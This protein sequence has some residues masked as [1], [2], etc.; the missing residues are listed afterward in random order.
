MGLLHTSFVSGNMFT[1][2]SDYGTT[3][4]SGI[5]EFT[6]RVNVQSGALYADIAN[7]TAVSGAYVATSGAL[8]TDI[9][10]L[11]AVSGA[12]YAVSGAYVATSGATY[13]FSKLVS[14]TDLPMYGNFAGI[15]AGEG[16][17]FTAGSVIAGEDASATNKGIIEIATEDEVQTGTDTIRAVVPDTLQAVMSPVGSIVAWLK[18]LAGVPQTLPV[19]WKECDGSAISDADSPM[20]GQNT[21]DLN[22]GEFLRGSSTT[23]G[24]GGATTSTATL[25][26]NT[27]ASPGQGTTYVGWNDGN[28]A[29]IVK[30]TN[31]GTHHVARNYSAAFS[32]IPPYYNVVW[33]M[34][35]K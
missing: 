2:G 9:A 4:T 15:Y 18:T 10:N 5:N 30:G 24:T 16:I 22:G 21:P 29:L 34:R 19:G 17:D 27:S 31:T 23:G 13:S 1:A 25:F 20:N 11:V 3:G 35:I 26:S 33:I 8:V 28:D 32:I 7:L 6:N 12:G 14:G